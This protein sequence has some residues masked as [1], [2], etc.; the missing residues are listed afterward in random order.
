M[1]GMAELGVLLGRLP[2]LDAFQRTDR[3]ARVWV[4]PDGA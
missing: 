4:W 2:D 1:A 3:V